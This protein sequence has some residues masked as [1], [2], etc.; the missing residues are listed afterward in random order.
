MRG[1]RS[2]ALCNPDT[3]RPRAHTRS[4]AASTPEPASR[5]RQTGGARAH[6]EG[7]AP[8][9]NHR[10]GDRRTASWPAR[11]TTIPHGRAPA[12][13]TGRH[14]RPA[15]TSTRP[16]ATARPHQPRRPHQPH[17]PADHIYPPTTSTTTTTRATTIWFRHHCL[18]GKRQHRQHRQHT[19]T[20]PQR[21]HHGQ[22]P[23]PATNHANSPCL[24]CLSTIAS[25]QRLGPAWTN[26]TGTSGERS[27]GRMHPHYTARITT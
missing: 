9:A 20:S 23:R 3:R 8:T 10:Q 26:H 12:R 21:A 13:H 2:R 15:P 18:Q 7:A 14:Q 17:L 1:R 24:R 22:T 27:T 25:S 4:A 5:T 19:P 6:L 11:E 16:C